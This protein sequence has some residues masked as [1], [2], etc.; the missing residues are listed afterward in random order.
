MESLTG[1]YGFFDQIGSVT[2]SERLSRHADTAPGCNAD[3]ANNNC[4]FCCRSA[5]CAARAGGARGLA[6]A[7]QSTERSFAAFVAR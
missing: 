2:A 3:P 4:A 5:Q 1:D 6:N 7:D